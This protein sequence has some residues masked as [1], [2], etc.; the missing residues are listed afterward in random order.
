MVVGAIGGRG[1][2]ALIKVPPKVKINADWY[3]THVLKPILEIH[4]PHKYGKDTAKVFVHHDAATSHTSN[5]TEQYTDDIRR[6]LGITVIRKSDIPIKSPDISPMDFFGFGYLKQR[7]F[8]RKARTLDGLWKVVK[9]EWS[10]LQP[11][12]CAEVFSAWKRRLRTCAKMHGAHIEQTKTI[13]R[14]R[15]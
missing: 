12:K 7:L 8:H 3:I 14:R 4:I 11:E 6:R 15:I 1:T 2:L 5:K 10:K 13:H 9:D